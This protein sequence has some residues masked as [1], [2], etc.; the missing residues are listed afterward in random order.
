M[1]G[2][3]TCLVGVNI[4]A[5]KNVLVENCTIQGFRSGNGNGIRDARTASTIPA[6]QLWVNNTNIWNTSGSGI[7]MV[8]AAG[9]GIRGFFERVTVFGGGSHGIQVQN[10]S[11]A[12][13]RFSNL[14]G[15][16]GDGV[17]VETNAKVNVI[18]SMLSGNLNGLNNVGGTVNLADVTILNNAGAG[19]SGTVVSF[20]NNNVRDNISGNSLPAAVGQQ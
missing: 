19:V 10:S 1:N 5:A 12:H 8:G 17:R 20:G 13:I 4:T 11:V 16:L 15:D 6:G 14:S 2:A 18:S 7:I 3:T 9:A